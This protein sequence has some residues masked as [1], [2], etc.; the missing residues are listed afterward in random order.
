M[1]KK[2]PR[3]MSLDELLTEEQRLRHAICELTT[4][5]ERIEE[6]LDE[7][8]TVQQCLIPKLKKQH[9]Q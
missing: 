9:N 3:E 1:P 6:L 7:F 2:K 8:K 5:Q 4:S